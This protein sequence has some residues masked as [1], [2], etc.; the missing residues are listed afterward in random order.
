M[1][2]VC[3]SRS[4]PNWLNLKAQQE[5]HARSER[6]RKTLK[7]SQPS[8]EESPE[9]VRMR[10]RR[11]AEILASN[12][13]EGGVSAAEILSDMSLL[14]ELAQLQE[15]MVM[16][17]VIKASQHIQ[18]LYHYIRLNLP[19]RFLIWWCFRN[20]SPLECS[21]LPANFAKNLQLYHPPN[22]TTTTIIPMSILLRFR[23]PLYNI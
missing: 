16:F 5:F 4:L 20:G 7:R 10:N 3:V 9:D 18:T 1:C 23:L 17:D 2:S 13:G 19:D 14:K 8:E 21:N 11:E 12:L 6:N 15:S 22:K